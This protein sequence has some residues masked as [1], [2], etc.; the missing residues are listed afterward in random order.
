[1]HFSTTNLQEKVAQLECIKFSS[2]LH[3]RFQ[4]RD[5]ESEY[6]FFVASDKCDNILITEGHQN[7][8]STQDLFLKIISS[9]TCPEILE[10]IKFVGCISKER[11]YQVNQSIT[12]ALEILSKFVK[13]AD[14]LRKNIEKIQFEELCDKLKILFGHPEQDPEPQEKRT[15]RS[16]PAQNDLVDLTESQDEKT[17]TL[18][19][20]DES[21]WAEMACSDD[22]FTTTA[23]PE[24]WKQFMDDLDPSHEPPDEF[25]EESKEFVSKPEQ[26]KSPEPKRIRRVS[27]DLD[28]EESSSQHQTANQSKYSNTSRSFSQADKS[29]FNT[30]QYT[31]TP[32]CKSTPQLGRGLDPSKPVVLTPIQEK[33]FPKSNL[34]NQADFREIRRKTE[35]AK[36][37]KK[38]RLTEALDNDYQGSSKTQENFGVAKN[39]LQEYKIPKKADSEKQ[40]GKVHSRPAINNRSTIYTDHVAGRRDTRVFS[41]FTK[42]TLVGAEASDGYSPSALARKSSYEPTERTVKPGEVIEL[43]EEVDDDDVTIIVNENDDVNNNQRPQKRKLGPL[44]I[45]PPQKDPEIRRNSNRIFTTK[46]VSRSRGPDFR[47]HDG[48]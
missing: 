28:F 41:E 4:I 29:R 44:I 46:N 38:P 21:V 11:I 12:K 17:E 18:D 35:D 13:D 45:D 6:C 8:D 24:L 23:D 3:V 15:L 2:I 48:R 37:A 31:S 43:D 10:S 16:R 20:D 30:P 25:Y 7:P 14:N 1:M 34:F 36:N 42:K 19:P 39:F 27:I 22:E 5:A 32:Q 40:V 26:K 9:R 47:T 33:A